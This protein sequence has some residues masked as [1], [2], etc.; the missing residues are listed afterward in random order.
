[1]NVYPIP[2]ALHNDYHGSGYAIV[3]VKNNEV[4]AI[5]YLH[6]IDD[7]FYF[8]DDT[9]RETGETVGQKLTKLFADPRCGAVSKWMAELGSVH[10][11]MV[12]CWEFIEL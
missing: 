11:G 8:D 4:T 3:A 9:L 2:D 12:S 5:Q 10:A 7:E 6:K 1:M